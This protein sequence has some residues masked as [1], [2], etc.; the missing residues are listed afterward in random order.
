MNDK[1]ITKFKKTLILK[2]D[3]D[4]YDFIINNSTI[5]FMTPSDFISCIIVS[6]KKYIEKAALIAS[7]VILGGI[8]EDNE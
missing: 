3:N 7:A 8:D 4:L 1:K 2:I 6:K 5:L